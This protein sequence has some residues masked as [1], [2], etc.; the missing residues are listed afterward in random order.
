MTKGLFSRSA[1]SLSLGGV[2]AVLLTGLAATPALAGTTARSIPPC[3]PRLTLS[4]V[5]CR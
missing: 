4:T 3:A 1:R 2:F 5:S